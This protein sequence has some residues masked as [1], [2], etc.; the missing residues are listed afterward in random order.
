[1][2]EEAQQEEDDS[3]WALEMEEQ[4][5]K[6]EEKT[7]KNREKRNKRK[8]KSKGKKEGEGTSVDGEEGSSAVGKNKNGV[9]KKPLNIPKRD[10]LEE[11]SMEGE[12]TVAGQISENG[13]TIH[14]ED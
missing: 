9:V 11:K 5:K 2:D 8:G 4:R 14:D 1:M 7:R 13:I 12:S 6:D 3:K 10:T